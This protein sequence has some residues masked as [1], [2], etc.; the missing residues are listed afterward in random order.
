MKDF[1]IHSIVNMYS[2]LH[3][4]TSFQKKEKKEHY[5]DIIAPHYFPP[6]Y[7]YQSPAFSIQTHR[8]SLDD[9]IKPFHQE[10]KSKT[11]GDQEI[12]IITITSQP[13]Y[14][15]YTDCC[16]IDASS[17]LK[18][19]TILDAVAMN[20][21]FYQ[22]QIDSVPLG[23]YKQ[24]EKETF[25]PLQPCYE[26][27]YRAITIS[28]EG[29][30]EIHSNPFSN[31]WNDRHQYHSMMACAPL[32]IDQGE[33]VMTD[34]LLSS[35]THEGI[36]VLQCDISKPY[37]RGMNVER[38]GKKIK[39]CSSNL[40]GGLFHISNTNPRSVLITDREGNVYF[41]RVV[42]RMNGVLGMDLV[43]VAQTI[44]RYIPNAWMA[45]NLDGG[46]PSQLL[47]KTNGTVMSTTNQYSH[48]GKS[49]IWIGN[50][51][52]YMKVSDSFS[53]LSSFS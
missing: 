41:M 32:L 44:K 7:S 28:N 52:S 13:G 6:L 25:R 37:E 24:G 53:P 42:G 15:F 29:T 40:P 19:D 36:H 35:Y 27:F 11:Y 34:E 39:S 45:I 30:L 38:N 1:I 49:T 43:Q 5:Q 50:L 9:P 46:A 2:T 8:F 12:A 4:Y 18:Q 33:I 23:G 14:R 48:T 47:H 26:P 22:F 10:T 20:G 51:L 3:E 17:Y 16:T 31:T 21:V